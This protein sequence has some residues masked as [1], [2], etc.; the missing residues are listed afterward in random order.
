MSSSFDVT[1]TLAAVAVPGV[2]EGEAAGVGVVFET[3]VVVELAAVVEAA[4]VETASCAV[5]TFVIRNSAPN[6]IGIFFIKVVCRSSFQS[7]DWFV[8]FA[9]WAKP[10]QK[11]RICTNANRDSGEVA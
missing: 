9:I 6:I 4:G 3:E 11:R 8:A 2:G 7:C 5:A 1:W 10:V